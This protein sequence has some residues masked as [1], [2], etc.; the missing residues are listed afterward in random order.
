METMRTT[1]GLTVPVGYGGNSKSTA[2]ETFGGK[3]IKSVA[4]AQRGS[5]R[6]RTFPA[7]QVTV[8]TMLRGQRTFD[9][10]EVLHVTDAENG[11][12]TLTVLNCRT[13]EVRHWT[14]KVDFRVELA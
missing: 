12:V 4:R 3:P 5:P 9:T 11:S 8:G 14:R 13:T 1:N 10:Y 7:G 6:G 2:T